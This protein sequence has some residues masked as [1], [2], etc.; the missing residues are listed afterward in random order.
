[1]SPCRGSDVEKL[2][3]FENG[4]LQYLVPERLAN[5]FTFAEHD[6]ERVS[7]SAIVIKD[8]YVTKNRYG[9]KSPGRVHNHFPYNPPCN[10][11]EVGGQL[12]GACLND[13]GS[14]R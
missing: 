8:G 10:E 9:A 12:R 4:G 11:R 14:E 3:H 2:V 1:M 5:Q 13:D 7:L 6:M